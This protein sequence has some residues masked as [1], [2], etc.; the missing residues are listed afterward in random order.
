MKFM[1]NKKILEAQSKIT[2]LK[3]N[4]NEMEKEIKEWKLFK[5]FCKMEIKD[6]CIKFLRNKEGQLL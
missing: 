4:I 2:I 6:F 3:K 1:F 5:K